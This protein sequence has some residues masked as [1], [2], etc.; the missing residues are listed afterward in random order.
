MESNYIFVYGLLKSMYDNDPARFIRKKSTLIGKAYFPGILI[1]IGTYP[2]AIYEPGS[3]TKV[4]GE[5]YRIDQ[6]HK[7][8]VAFLDHFEGVGNQFKQPNEYIR[9]VI[10]VQID[11]KNILASCYLYNW[12]YDVMKVIASGRYE[13]K[14]GNRN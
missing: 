4:H 10:S 14:K 13:N 2:G 5:V 8:L 9:E 11:E 3:Q 1:D 12:N 6:N 7:E